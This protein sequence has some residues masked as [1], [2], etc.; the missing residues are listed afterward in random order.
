MSSFSWPLLC[1]WVILHSAHC[2]TFFVFYN[3]R[4]RER[5]VGLRWE[6]DRLFHSK[7]LFLQSDRERFAL[8]AVE[9]RATV[10]QSLS[11]LIVPLSKNEQFAQKNSYF[12]PC[13]DSFL[14]RFRFLCPKANCSHCSLQKSDHE[15][16][17]PIAL[18]Q[19]S[20]CEWIAPIALY[21]R[22]TSS[23]LLPLLFTKERPWAIRFRPLY[24]RAMGAIRHFPRVNRYFTH[25][26]ERF[27]WKTRERIP[28]PGDW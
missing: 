15:Q 9:K 17:A 12:S 22:A 10:C 6:F 8:V 24:K 13:F 7:L 3:I 19:K 14:L 21:K 11:L 16:I 28:S 20:D 4:A 18:K 5:I 25:K 23:E 2:P 1:V 27:A 26:N